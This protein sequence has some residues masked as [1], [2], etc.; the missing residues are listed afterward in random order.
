MNN[1]RVFATVLSLM[2]SASTLAQDKKY[3]INL[4]QQYDENKAYPLFL[5]L[6]GG[7]GNM[8]DI[9]RWWNNRTLKASYVV[10]YLEASTLDRAPDRW[11]WRDVFRE[12]RNISNYFEEITSNY[13]IDTTK[14]FAGGFSLGA[15]M[16]VDLLLA[17]VIPLRGVV[18]LNHG[19]RLSTAVT[20]DNIRK[21]RR[22][23][24]RIV[25]MVGS[26]DHRYR[27]ESRQLRDLLKAEGF[28]FE[29]MLNQGV[30]H[31]RPPG[32]EQKLDQALRFLRH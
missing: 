31:E 18:S 1:N 25:I 4:P 12:R 20:A 5:V 6:H 32:F 23:H 3:L 13:N 14:V 17:D 8:Q 28:V 24:K 11:G 2:I 19:G 27:R 21:A 15:K 9:S 7:N 26:E 10:A 30:G 22:A 16:S 29:Y